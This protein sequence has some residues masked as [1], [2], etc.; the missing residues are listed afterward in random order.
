MI[1][2]RRARP[3]LS[4]TTQPIIWPL[5]A[6]PATCFLSTP[7]RSA[8]LFS[9]TARHQSSGFCSAQVLLKKFV[10]YV[11][12]MLL[13]N[14][15]SVVNSVALSPEVPRSC[16]IKYV[17]ILFVLL[18]FPGFRS[19]RDSALSAAR[20]PPSIP[21]L[22]KAPGSSRSLPALPA[23]DPTPCSGGFSPAVPWKTR[24]R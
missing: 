21:C 1:A 10:G 8:L 11:Q 20:G 6:M 13:T 15:P 16:A 12:V 7:I 23:S 24:R 17:P 3:S 18:P 19:R 5:N 14:S 9:Q 2:G 4:T 22:Q